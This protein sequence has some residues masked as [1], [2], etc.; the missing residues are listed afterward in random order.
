QQA[1]DQE[2]SATV[3]GALS[4]LSDEHRAVLVMRFCQDMSLKETAEALEIPVGTVKSRQSEA[5]RQLRAGLIEV[6]L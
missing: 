4:K 5:A 2:E 6:Q 3:W 1:L